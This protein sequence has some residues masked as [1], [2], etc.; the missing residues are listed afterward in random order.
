MDINQLKNLN[1]GSNLNPEDMNLLTNLLGNINSGKGLQMSTREKNNLL[2]KLSSGPVLEANKKELKNMN[3]SEKKIYREELRAK[4]N[5]VQNKHKQTRTSKTHL[6]KQLNN[7]LQTS[8]N[9]DTNNNVEETIK[10]IMKNTNFDLNNF[11][12][13]DA[14]KSINSIV[15]KNNPN[16]NLND[17]LTSTTNTQQESANTINVPTFNTKIENIEDY[18]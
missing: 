9:T 2:S 7:T 1:L 5:A 15:G 6:K 12:V 14:V 8:S 16:F 3:E 4:M 11:N 10:S 13:E 17:V 18:L